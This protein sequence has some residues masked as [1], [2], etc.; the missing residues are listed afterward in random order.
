MIIYILSSLLFGHYIYHNFIITKP[1]YV[2]LS[3]ITQFMEKQQYREDQLRKECNLNY[4]HIKEKPPY[5]KQVLS[6]L[7]SLPKLYL[8]SNDIYIHSIQEL[9]TKTTSKNI[10]YKGMI[11][12]ILQNSPQ[13]WKLTFENHEFLIYNITQ[14][15]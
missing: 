1:L 8:P 6:S 14:I 2:N 7:I 12:H 9:L 5:Y 13:L 4:Y 3:D 11:F 15:S 10:I